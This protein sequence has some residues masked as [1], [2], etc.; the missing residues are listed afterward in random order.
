MAVCVILL[1]ASY[2]SHNGA[3][4]YFTEADWTLAFDP[5][6][7]Y[8]TIQH[9]DLPFEGS[10]DLI[11]QCYNNMGTLMYIDASASSAGD[12]IIRSKNPFPGQLL[13]FQA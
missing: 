4:Y 6:D 2:I 10:T 9:S 12:V 7:Y 1:L 3:R 11:I 8:I 5:P 13:R